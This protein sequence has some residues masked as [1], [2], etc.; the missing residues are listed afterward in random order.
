MSVKRKIYDDGAIADRQEENTKKTNRML[1]K[2]RAASANPKEI[3]VGDAI[4]AFYGYSNPVFD[5]TIYDSGREC[6]FCGERTISSQRTLCAKCMQEYGKK[7]F[8]KIK[9]E[10]GNQVIYL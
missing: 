6:V 3:T 7:I 5:F 9:D 4:S 1:R 2:A 8:E 10:L